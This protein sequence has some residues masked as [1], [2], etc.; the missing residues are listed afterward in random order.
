MKDRGKGKFR[1]SQNKK[2]KKNREK[3]RFLDVEERGEERRAER[4]NIF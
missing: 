2:K 1:V 3:E 4:R